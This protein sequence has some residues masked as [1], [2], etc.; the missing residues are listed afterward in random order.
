[1][2]HL[3]TLSLAVVAVVAAMAFVGASTAS[4]TTLCKVS[5]NPCPEAS[6]Y[7]LPQTIKGATA[8]GA[9]AT[10]T[11]GSFV[12]KCDST[13][14]G[15]AKENLGAGKGIK[16]QITGL[17][18]TNCEGSCTSAEAKNL[19]YTALA[20]AGAGGNGSMTVEGSPFAGAQ[21]NNCFGS[22]TCI[23]GAAKVSLEI[24]GGNPAK[25]VAKAVKLTK[26]TGS[27][28]LCPA[29]GSWT[30]TYV[31]SEPNPVWITAEP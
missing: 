3:K 12:V 25:I 1:M 26:Q 19:P 28:A 31:V 15:V 30:A 20:Q 14:T 21:L 4:A 29:E 6:R 16:G 22:V 18:F 9:K 7:A 11:A 10:L 5:T 8:A 23:Y 2:K 24:V 27:N 13:A 17:T